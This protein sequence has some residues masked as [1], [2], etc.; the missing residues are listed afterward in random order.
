MTELNKENLEELIECVKNEPYKE[1]K[2]LFTTDGKM[3]GWISVPICSD[4]EEWRKRINLYDQKG[5]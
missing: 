4:N 5:R 3:I 1:T 2:P